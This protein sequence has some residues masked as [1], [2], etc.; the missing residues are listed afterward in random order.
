MSHS[1]VGLLE[2]TVNS[3]I[4]PNHKANTAREV[5]SY[6]HATTNTHEIHPVYTTLRK[7]IHR[8]LVAS[9]TIE[10]K[11][12]VDE[13]LQRLAAIVNTY[14]CFSFCFRWI[15]SGGY[16]KF[17]QRRIH[18]FKLVGKEIK[19]N[20][21]QSTPNIVNSQGTVKIGSLEPEFIITGVTWFIVNFFYKPLRL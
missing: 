14:L 12:S 4:S 8:D 5:E 13:N 16:S 2:V 17:W 9:K 19:F 21:L 7:C 1:H 20:R 3:T 15:S 18:R 11:Y 10:S 6:P